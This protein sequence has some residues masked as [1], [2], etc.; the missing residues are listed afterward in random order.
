MSFSWVGLWA[1]G[2]CWNLS[3]CFFAWPLIDW[4][5]VSFCFSSPTNHMPGLSVACF[6]SLLLCTP[7][8][9]SFPFVLSLFFFSLYSLY[10][11]TPA[12]K[13]LL[14]GCPLFITTRMVFLS[15]CCHNTQ[16]RGFSCSASTFSLNKGYFLCLLYMRMPS[17]ELHP[18]S[19]A[20]IEQK[21]NSWFILNQ[22]TH[23]QRTHT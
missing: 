18:F 23:N 17:H 1:A 5:L 15:F 22:R 7:L 19:K 3:A 8:L 10:W 9:I 4:W 13:Y 2:S 20:S 16:H 11:G 14:A 21:E 6:G 12:C